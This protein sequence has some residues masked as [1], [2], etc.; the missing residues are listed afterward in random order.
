[1][2]HYIDIVLGMALRNVVLTAGLHFLTGANSECGW[3][4]LLFVTTMMAVLDLYRHLKNKKLPI[5]P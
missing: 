2:L 5:A 1:M 4:E 3:Y